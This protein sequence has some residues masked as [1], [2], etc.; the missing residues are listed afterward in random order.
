MET[1]TFI[2]DPEL[3]EE[4]IQNFI[5]KL[6][7]AP[8][9]SISF[10]QFSITKFSKED[11]LLCW[12]PDDKSIQLLQQINSESPSLAFLPHPEL[13]LLAKSIGIPSSKE[14]AFELFLKAE[15]IGEID[16]L[17]VNEQLCTNSLVIGEPL[18][19]LYDTF[20][21]SYFQNLKKRVSRFS[22]LFKKVKLKS[23]TIN[24]LVDQEEKSIQIAALGILAGAHGENNLFFKKTIG[25][26]G[27]DDGMIHLAILAPKSLF[28]VLVIGFKNIFTPFKRKNIPPFLSYISS[29]KITIEAQDEFAYAL[30][31]KESHSKALHLMLM[32]EKARVLTGFE[33][34]KNDI[35]VP[36]EL[37]V[38]RL[39]SGKLKEELTK[40]NL[41]LF[42][43]A[44][45]EEFKDLFTLLKKNA[46]TSSTYL[47]LM[48]LSTLIATFG[49]FA[50]SGPVVIGAMILAPLM[51]PI[52][53]LSM[54]TLR[55][56][57]TLIKASLFSV[58]WGIVL[59][60]CFAILITW[61]T[62]LKTM[63]PEILSRIRPNLLDLGV[64]VAS[65]IAGAYAH[66]KEEIAKTLAGVA[67]SVA[68][69]PPLSV[70]GI[71]LGWGQWNIF[72]GASLLL[73]TN[74]AGIVMAAAFTFLILGYSPFRLARKGLVISGL[75]LIL[76]T[77]PLVLS[78]SEMVRENRVIQ[79]LSGKE[80]PHGLL[81]DVKVIGLSPL[82]LSVTV[83]SDQ[84]LEQEDYKAIKN[85]IEEKIGQTIELELTLG[86]KLIE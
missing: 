23:F 31:G 28:S 41:P 11:S 7:P 47:V 14:P 21:S 33:K 79:E 54:G 65:G 68:L 69:V 83:L 26:S 25:D 82:R 22:K 80:I 59:G 58:F 29:P 3:P 74:L 44:T 19:V 36:K 27:L 50:N 8:R 86:I 51:G 72:W 71:G 18:S 76:I 49:I 73:G 53:S 40:R 77:A 64:A 35:P 15:T 67:I 10:D 52:I 43:H 48:A 17:K 13:Q 75:I 4:E 66:S 81:R 20:E 57:S 78:F 42:R 70:A 61:M 16:I 24:Y 12:L 62:P 45:T 30:D 9:A 56:D 63:N 46:Q 38:S 6:S 32:E 60:L 2:Y 1:Y 37:N 84:K 55:Q 39:P 34:Q 5:S 85:E